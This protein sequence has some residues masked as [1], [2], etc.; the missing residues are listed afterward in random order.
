MRPRAT[1]CPIAEVSLANDREAAERIHRL[2][3]PIYW[4]AP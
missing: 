1:A 2:S 4:Q 3:T